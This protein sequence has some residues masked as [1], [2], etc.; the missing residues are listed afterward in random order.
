M[1]ETAS[2]TA[3]TNTAAVAPAATP[4]SAPASNNEAAEGL[5]KQADM[6]KEQQM[7]AAKQLEKEKSEKSA[8]QKELEFYRAKAAAEAEEYKKQQEPKFNEYI[9]QLQITAGKKLPESKI[10]QYKTLFTVPQFKEDADAMYAQHKQ[11]VEL[12]AS[13]KKFEEELAKERAE[14]AQLMATQSK[15]SQQVGGMRKSY[16]DALSAERIE[17]PARKEVG[18]AASLN[19]NEIM[20]AMPSV[21]DLPFLQKYGFSNEVGV[22]A[23]ASGGGAKLIRTSVQAAREHRLLL[24]E[25]GDL[26]FPASARYHNPTVFAWMVNEAPLNTMDLSDH[27]A[28]NASRTFVEEKRVD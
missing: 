17:E 14:K 12:R 16:A 21:A 8:M 19:A 3:T 27:V 10:A 23:S 22:N 4:A 13:A 28:I 1:S 25:D 24:D 7:E 5:L 9:E 20:A 18:V 2:A 26:Q 11:T 15:L 6:L